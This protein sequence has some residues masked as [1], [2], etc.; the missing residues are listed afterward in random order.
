MS[1]PNEDCLHCG[2]PATLDA[3]TRQA[4]HRECAIRMVVGSVGHLLGQCSCFGGTR[5]DP[6]A[7]STREAARKAA[8]LSEALHNI[9][10]ARE[11]IKNLFGALYEESGHVPS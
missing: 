9:D 8:S 7:L 3:A 1:E 5:E 10:A 11:N 4:L 6:P 2:E